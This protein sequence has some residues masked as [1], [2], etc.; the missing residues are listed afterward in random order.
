MS[1]P[2]DLDAIEARAKAATPG[3]WE[4]E[5]NGGMIYAYEMKMRVLDIRGWGYLTGWG[6]LHMNE[7]AAIKVQEA[8]G[9]FA[10][11]AREDVPALIA[12]LR[13]LREENVELRKMLDPTVVWAAKQ[14]KNNWDLHPAGCCGQCSAGLAE[15]DKLRE[16]NRWIPVTERLP[17]PFVDVL[18]GWGKRVE[19]GHRIQSAAKT[20]VLD[21][22]PAFQ[23]GRY[24]I[25]WATHWMPIRPLPK[26]PEVG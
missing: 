18:I 13:K 5:K 22:Q 9:D 1:E 11:H 23:S 26:P 24:E 19:T 2:L 16:E 12:E 15:R 25:R 17:E 20:A 6:G 21:Q 7:E 8:N 4:H 10:A 14:Q 3:P